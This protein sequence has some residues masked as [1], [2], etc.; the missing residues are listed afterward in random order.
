MTDLKNI[1]FK[2]S[3]ESVKKIIE[4]TDKGKGIIP[5][6]LRM[7]MKAVPK[8]VIG[9][10]ILLLIEAIIGI[11]VTW[12]YVLGLIVLAIAWALFSYFWRERWTF[13]NYLKGKKLALFSYLQRKKLDV[14]SY[15]QRKSK[16]KNNKTIS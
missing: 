11:V 5:A 1:D 7:V 4:K 16:S 8:P 14:F 2:K 6:E 12:K 3:T 10:V 9:I 15:F 13:I